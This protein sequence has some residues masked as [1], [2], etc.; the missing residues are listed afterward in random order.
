LRKEPDRGGEEKGVGVAVLWNFKLDD[1]PDQGNEEF[2][3]G[4]KDPL[5]LFLG[6]LKIA[7]RNTS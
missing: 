1:V 6:D 2:W 4:S 5:D 3:G 7:S